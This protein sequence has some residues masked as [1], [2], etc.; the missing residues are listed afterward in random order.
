MESPGA[1]CNS[2]LTRASQS[3]AAMASSSGAGAESAPAVS[4]AS[5]AAASNSPSVNHSPNRPKTRPA[6]GASTAIS[7]SLR[8]NNSLWKWW[9]G[10]TRVRA[11]R[12]LGESRVRAP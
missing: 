11:D 12:M 9:S 10:L 8:W 1:N 4:R 7:F 6:E 5:E 2:Y 3:I